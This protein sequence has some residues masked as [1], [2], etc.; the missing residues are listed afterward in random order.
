[1]DESWLSGLLS[2]SSF[3]LVLQALR[4]RLMRASLRL[5]RR[6]PMRVPYSTLVRCQVRVPRWSE[7]TVYRNF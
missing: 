2:E 7:V 5:H 1:M 6:V 3:V 4:E